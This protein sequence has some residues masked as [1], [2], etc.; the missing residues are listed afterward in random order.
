M[1]NPLLKPAA[2]RLA[3]AKQKL[4]EQLNA[5]TANIRDEEQRRLAAASWRQT[6]RSIEREIE[7]GAE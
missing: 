7:L 6:V 2:E 5:R 1:K 4:D 3:D